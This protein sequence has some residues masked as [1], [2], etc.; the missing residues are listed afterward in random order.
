MRANGVW[1]SEIGVDG[2]G[3]GHQH[4]S[5][6]LQDVERGREECSGYLTPTFVPV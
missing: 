6:E 5:E 1:I 3:G 4:G 2:S